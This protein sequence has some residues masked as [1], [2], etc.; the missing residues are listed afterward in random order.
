MSYIQR[1]TKLIGTDLEL[2]IEAKA[3]RIKEGEPPRKHPIKKSA[4]TTH[5]Q[6]LKIT[7][8]WLRRCDIIMSNIS[9]RDLMWNKKE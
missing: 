6:P 5:K 2:G 3:I 4:I 7:C 9:I 1:A 8:N